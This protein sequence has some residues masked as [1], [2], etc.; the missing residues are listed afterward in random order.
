[1]LAGDTLEI[2][3]SRAK[4]ENAGVYEYS[5]TTT[6]AN[7]TLVVIPAS[8]TIEKAD[9][10]I[11]ANNQTFVYDGTV[12]EIAASLDTEGALNYRITL[13]GETVDKILNAG[14]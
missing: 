13:A 1:M 7:Y 11:T 6:N 2:A 14:E 5:A 9:A 3:V 10:I 12:K 8:L 4:G